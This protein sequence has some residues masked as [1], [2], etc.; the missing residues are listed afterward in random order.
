MVALEEGAMVAFPRQSVSGN[1][2]A[3]LRIVNDPPAAPLP[4][5]IIGE[6][7]ELTVEDSQL[8]GMAAFRLPLPE[9]V[10]PDEYEL[11]AYR[12][13]GRAWE[14][15]GGR[16]GEGDI[17]FGSNVPALYSV[18]GRWRAGSAQLLLTSPVT[19]TLTASVPISVTGQYRYTS[20]PRIVDGLVPAR[21]TLKRDSSGGAGQVTGN[22]ALDE[23][24]TESPLL[25]QPDPASAQGVVD[26]EY[27][28]E[29]PPGAVDVPPGAAARFYAILTVEDSAAPTRQSSTA[30]EQVQ[31]FP[32]KIVG[33]EVIRPALVNEDRLPLRWHVQ[34]NGATLSQPAATDL[35][36]PL[37]P[38]LAQGGVG[39]YRILL[40]AQVGDQWE[41]ASNVVTVTLAVPGTQ[42]P[43]PGPGTAEGGVIADLNTGATPTPTDTPPAVPTRR[44][45]PVMATVTPTATLTPTVQFTA[46]T[47]TPVRPDWA[48]VFWADVYAVSPG[49]CTT[50]HWNIEDIDEVY[51]NGVGVTG[52][53][54]QRVC[55]D[56]TT[57]YTLRAVKGDKSQSWTV[58][59]RV[60][61]GAQTPFEFS[62]DQYEIT[63]G[64]CTTLRWKATNVRAVYLNGEGVPGEAIRQECPGQTTLYELRVEDTS[65]NVSTRTLTVSVVPAGQVLIRL[66]SEQYTLNPGTCTTIHWSVN[67]V[68]AVYLDDGAS[69]RGVN[70]VDS[71]SVCPAGD[72]TYTIRAVAPDGGSSEKAITLDVG[73]PSLRPN[74]AIVQAV[75]RS[76]NRTTDVD[77][78]L[79]GDQ[80]GWLLTVDGVNPLFRGPG[81]CCQAALTLQVP[82]AYTTGGNPV[83]W[84]ISAGQLIEFRGLCLN[85]SCSMPQG[86]PFYLRLR[87]N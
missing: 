22:E 53:Q 68:Q 40:E 46:M 36:L 50:L 37:D 5:S 66:W 77:P 8:T 47:P 34:L 55:L 11:S 2:L 33:A 67:N 9:G 63:Q 81:D 38:I 51:L 82:Q 43:Q 4:R 79:G 3:N 86:T 48:S 29:V 84:P 76:V 74:E 13:N 61:A 70:G 12:W 35:A 26:F 24:V 71:L 65:G 18:Q 57:T 78:V 85:A 21:L 64:S 6:A 87:S 60:E 28:F 59:I 16:V 23:T 15:V 44:P 58:T 25:F 54:S 14:R 39:D 42:T 45:Q 75:V 72:T 52:N 20:P 27:A 49:G 31:F 32:I 17:Q 10:T 7:Y 83:D 19:Q 62:A 69:E 41:P 73:Q 80:P 1:A 30:V 56:A